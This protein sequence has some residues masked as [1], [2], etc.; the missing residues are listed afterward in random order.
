MSSFI[1]TRSSRPEVSCKKVV[2]KIKIL[3]NSLKNIR[4]AVF[5]LM[6]FQAKD[7]KIFRKETP[8]YVLS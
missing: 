4:D 1:N 6:K 8:A 2:L 7:L 3:Q 5:N